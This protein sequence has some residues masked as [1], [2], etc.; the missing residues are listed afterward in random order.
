MATERN[1]RWSVGAPII[2]DG[3]RWGVMGVSS[4]LEQPP[5][6]D[7]EQRLTQ[8][9]ELLAMAIA[10]AE[11]RAGLARLAEEQAALRR[12]ATLVARGSAPEE[13]CAA[14]VEEVKQLL[15]SD[16]AAM[17]RFEPDG[18]RTVIAISGRQ[19]HLF[20]VG[21]RVELGGKNVS[22]LV[23]ETG[24]PA[25]LDSYADAS[26]SL[27]VTLRDNGMRQAVGAPIIVEDRLWGAMIAGSVAERPLPA[28][29]ETR[30]VSFTEAFGGTLQLTSPA[31]SGTTLHIHLPV[32]E[33]TSSRPARR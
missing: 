28:G 7:T 11:S 29:S 12:V 27:G 6:P 3:R 17:I 10:N 8:F 25:R 14:V 16:T 33:A 5:P 30:L 32:E 9:M 1:L 2:V 19:T 31:G 18:T 13:V 26:G 21:E 23:F 24:R 15:G 22:T 20:P 4:T